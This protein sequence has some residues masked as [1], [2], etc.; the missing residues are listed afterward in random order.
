MNKQTSLGTGGSFL[1]RAAEVY[2]F[3]GAIT[4][5]PVTVPVPEGEATPAEAGAE[6]DPGQTLDLAADQIIEQPLEGE[7]AVKPA[8]R[9]PARRKG[10]RQGRPGPCLID[11]ER[12][13][14]GGFIVP[15]APTGALAEEFRIIKRQL[16]KGASGDS[17]L[18]KDKRQ[19]ILVASAQPAEGKSFCALNLALSIAAEKDVE[20]LLVDGDFAKPALPAAVGLDAGKGFIDAIGNSAIDPND[21]V[22]PTDVEGLS[23]LPAGRQAHNVTELLASARTREVL[24]ALT[25]GHENR[26]LIFDSTP[27]L[28]A[29]PASVLASHAGQ[30]MMVVRADRTTEADLRES[31]SLLS[32]CDSISLVLNGTRLAVSGPRF[33]V[34]YGYDQ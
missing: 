12:L 34:Y 11:R 19:M 30:V 27:A 20:V 22:V 16:L 25:E 1:E 2:D 6:P 29:S 32:S 18:A 31:L 24:R 4:G 10:A 15:E 21:L 5:R 17:A 26:I 23:L 3:H 13:R 7:A 14:E 9:K 8:D 33:G 28:L